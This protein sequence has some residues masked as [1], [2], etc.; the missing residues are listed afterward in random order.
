MER[1]YSKICGLPVFAADS[2]RPI[3]SVIDL[4]I[5]PNSGKVLA[6]L[7]DARKWLVV[8]PIDITAIKHGVFI[9]DYEDIIPAEDILRVKE[10]LNKYGSLYKKKVVTESGVKI[11]KIFDYVVDDFGGGNSGNGPHGQ[12]VGALSLKKIYT[13]KNLLGIAQFDGRIIMAANI[14]EV[15]PDRVIVKDDVLGARVKAD[16]SEAKKPG[17]E[18]AFGG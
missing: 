10:V 18:V 6:F 16:E 12:L 5:D 2:L 9:H 14:I 3:C 4:V 13:A 8:A 15:M 17:M 11:G 1:L 7:V